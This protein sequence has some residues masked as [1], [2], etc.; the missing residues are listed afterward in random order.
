MA[1]AGRTYVL[2]DEPQVT[3]VVPAIGRQLYNDGAG[4]GERHDGGDGLRLP[5]V[6]RGYFYWTDVAGKDVFTWNPQKS[7]RYRLWLS[8]GCGHATH[9]RDAVYQLD[10]DGDLATTARPHRHRPRRPPTFR[11]RRAAAAA[12]TSPT[13]RCGAGSATPASTS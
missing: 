6:G 4:P 1:N 2:V 9:A 8:W 7:G 10:A 12:A 3:Q 13:S 11:R 5:N